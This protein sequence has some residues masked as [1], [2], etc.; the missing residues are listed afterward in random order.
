[1]LNFQHKNGCKD[2]QRSN[3][4]WNY[5]KKNDF[6]RSVENFIFCIKNSK[7]YY[8]V[9]LIFLLSTKRL[10]LLVHVSISAH[11][12]FVILMMVSLSYK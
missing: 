7:E 11:A 3:L 8:A 9:C 10:V 2:H 12:H 1:M 6:T 5:I 4:E